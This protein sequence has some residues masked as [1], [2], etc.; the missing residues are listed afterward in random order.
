MAGLLDAINFREIANA[1]GEYAPS[2]ATA[3]VG[4]GGGIIV[5]LLENMFGVK[6]NALATAIAADP[7]AKEKLKALEMQHGETL[8]SLDTADRKNARANENTDKHFWI[9]ATLSII[10][11]LGFFSFIGLMLTQYFPSA[12]DAHQVFDILSNS[13]M[14]VLSYWFGSCHG[15]K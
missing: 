7:D 11:V 3:L 1:V 12:A 13:T 9:L 14:L 2:V 6:S 5:T 15:N 8:L 10:F 4:S